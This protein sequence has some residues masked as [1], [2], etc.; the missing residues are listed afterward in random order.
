VRLASGS[1]VLALALIAGCAG[2]GGPGDDADLSDPTT[3]DDGATLADLAGMDLV[4]VGDMASNGPSCN[5][6]NLA[7]GAAGGPD[8]CAYG[9]LCDA[10]TS[11]CAAVPSGSCNMVMGGPVWNKGAKL[12]PVIA[13]VSATLLATTDSMTECAAGDPAA[14]VTVDYY[15]PMNLTSTTMANVFLPQVKFKKSV[16]STDPWYSGTF[17]RQMP[18]ANTKNGTFKVGINCGGAGGAVKT[19][20]FY[21]VDEGGRTSNLVCVSW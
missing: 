14:L 10:A 21:I 7:L 11:K 19:A 3:V 4:K 5:P 9:E 18:A 15:A 20:G 16:V 1:F 8:T 2:A 6:A 13:K 12:A 17:M